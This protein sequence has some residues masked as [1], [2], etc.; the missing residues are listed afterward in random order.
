[1]SETDS[2]RYPDR[3]GTPGRGQLRIYLGCGRRGRQ[4]L[5]DARTRA[6]AR[7]SAAPTSW[8][9]FVETHGRQHTAEQVAGLEVDPAR[10]VPYRGSA[11][12]EMD[13]DAV[14][15]RQPR[16]RA[17]RRARPHQRARVAQREALAGRRGAARGRHRR[18]H[19]RQHPA[20]GVAQ[21]RGRED[22][23]RPAAGDRARRRGPRRRPGRAGRHDAGGAAAP[24]GARQRLPGR[25]DRRRADATTSGSAT[26]PRCASSPCSGSPT[27]STRACSGTARRTASTAPGR[28]ASGW[29]SR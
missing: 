19:H 15:A 24:D 28:P 11:F 23:R 3:P 29:S 12:E 27:R 5:R 18:H 20:P 22:H 8:S 16:G 21:R 4:D 2:A 9:R 10:V 1:M 25:E 7:A 13:L 17:G 26:S 6:T 14:L